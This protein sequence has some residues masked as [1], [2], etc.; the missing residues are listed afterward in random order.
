MSVFQAL[1]LAIAAGAVLVY[2]RYR[3]L[4]VHVSANRMTTAQAASTF[5]R[6]TVIQ[7]ILGGTVYFWLLLFGLPD[8]WLRNDMGHNSYGIPIAGLI[9]GGVAGA[10]MSVVGSRL[11]SK[12]P[13]ATKR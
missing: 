4:A 3:S 13:D 5:A 7:G 10:V 9:A 1:L 6:S 2:M 8:N 12:P 11:L